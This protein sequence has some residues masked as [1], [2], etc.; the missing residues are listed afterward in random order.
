MGNL[1][2]GHLLDDTSVLIYLLCA[3]ATAALWALLQR[4]ADD[5]RN[6]ATATLLL[7]FQRGEP[8]Y[9]EIYGLFMVT[10]D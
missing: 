10:Y 1:T 7:L 2:Q 5:C 8:Q 4:S 6:K 9:K 3:A